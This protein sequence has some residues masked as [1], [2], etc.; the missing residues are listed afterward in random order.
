M[1]KII[2]SILH[3]FKER[4][5][6][7]KVREDREVEY[8]SLKEMKSGLIFWTVEER[9][10]DWQKELKGRWEGI[11]FDRLCFVPDGVECSE[12]PEVVRLYKGDLG[13]GGKIRNERL[14]ELLAREYDLLIDLNKSATPIVNYVLAN[15]RA[16]LIVGG[17][18]EGGIADIRVAGAK[19]PRLFLN[20]LSEILAEIKKF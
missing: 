12:G 2:D 17:R 7:K 9:E 4:A 18:K 5:L 20:E 16:H 13:F 14:L 19:E 11:R 3:R 1:K 6:K 8:K 10:V 15:S